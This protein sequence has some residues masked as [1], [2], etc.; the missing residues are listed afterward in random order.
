MVTQDNAEFFQ[1][2]YPYFYD[3]VAQAKSLV[4]ESLTGPQKFKRIAANRY[5]SASIKARQS[6]TKGETDMCSCDGKCGEKCVLRKMFIECNEQHCQSVFVAHPPKCGNMR[7]QRKEHAAIEVRWFGKKG[8]GLV[9]TEPVK[10]GQFLVEYVCEI[11]DEEKC[12]KRL[13]EE[14]VGDKHS[15]IL[16]LANGEYIDATR[17]G[18][19][20]RFINHSC[21]PVAEAQKWNVN[22]VYRIGIFALKDCP[23]D[24][25]VTFD[26]K[27]E[28]FGAERTKCL[29]GSSRCRGYLGAKKRTGDNNGDS[30]DEENDA[31]LNVSA[32]Q[33]L[34]TVDSSSIDKQQLQWEMDL[35]A[36][37]KKPEVKKRGRKRKKVT[38]KKTQKSWFDQLDF[39]QKSLPE[40]VGN[41]WLRRNLKVVRKARAKQLSTLVNQVCGEQALESFC[42]KPFVQAPMQET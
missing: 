32:R 40:P 24:T 14:Y 4:K 27:F 5:A 20:A 21:D 8:W 18:C 23:V 29:C 26:Y 17:Q 10:K 13:L 33:T 38:G 16:T 6:G 39:D 22:G 15:Y 36:Y 42:A 12:Q 37:P 25:E 31:D 28:R 7:F 19:E 34:K 9:V 41:V 2:P 3:W 1:L 11:L 30:E 35:L